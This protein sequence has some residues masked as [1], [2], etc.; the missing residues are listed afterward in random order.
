MLVGLVTLLAGQQVTVPV[1]V[2]QEDMVPVEHQEQ[3]INA[4]VLAM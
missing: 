2:Q 3:R 1:P 4:Q